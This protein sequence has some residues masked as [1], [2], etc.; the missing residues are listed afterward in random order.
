MEAD[1]LE[2]VAPPE[3]VQTLLGHGALFAHLEGHANQ[4]RLPGGLLLHGPRGIGKATFAFALARK[5]LIATGDESEHRVREQVAA[6][7]HPNLQVLRRVLREKS[8]GY[9]SEIRVDEVRAVLRKL[10][11]TRGRAGNR[12]LIIDAV[13]DCNINAT[14]ALLKTLEEPPAQTH[15]ILISHRPGRLLPTIRSRCQ[16]YPLRPLETG[17]VQEILLTSGAADELIKRVVPLAGGRPRRGFEALGM[18]ENDILADLVSWLDAPQVT[19]VT[20]MMKTAEALANKKNIT[21]AGFAREMILDWIAKEARLAVRDIAEFPS[22]LA[23]INKL[24]EKANNVFIQTD[25]YNL[26]MR[27]SF[28]TLLDDI[29]NHVQNKQQRT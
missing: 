8:S 21:E 9:Y 24:W 5:I 10:H 22:R 3:T 19:G 7:V 23:S 28:I 17:Q 26:D 12:L 1:G 6:G 15:I 11:Q 18:N 25:T 16:A 29:A 27:Q 4:G 20:M 13:D 2:G 14:N